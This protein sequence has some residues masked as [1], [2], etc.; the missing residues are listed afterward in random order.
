MHVHIPNNKPRI[1]GTY[2][3]NY[4]SGIRLNRHLRVSISTAAAPS[5]PASLESELNDDDDDDDDGSYR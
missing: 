4:N 3:D 2:F 5:T 1:C